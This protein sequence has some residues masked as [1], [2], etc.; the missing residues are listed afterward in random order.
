MGPAPLG[1]VKPL[2]RRSRP[3]RRGRAGEVPSALGRWAEEPK[4]RSLSELSL[5]GSCCSSGVGRQMNAALLTMARVLRSRAWPLPPRG[6]CRPRRPLAGKGSLFA[7][8]G[9]G[10]ASPGAARRNA[11]RKNKPH[12][13]SRGVYFAPMARPAASATELK[14]TE[15][16]LG[17][18]GRKGLFFGRFCCRGSPE[19][20]RQP[21]AGSQPVSK[22]ARALRVVLHHEAAPWRCSAPRLPGTLRPR[23]RPRT[24]RLRPARARRRTG[25]AAVQAEERLRT[26]ERP[27]GASTKTSPCGSPRPPA[28]SQVAM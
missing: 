28:G 14:V 13:A 9:V 17:L 8:L 10:L 4:L 19:M 25:G 11:R 15:Y 21:E 16:L 27:P 24:R 18:R 1:A 7:A 22:A 20:Q 26:A 12:R 6:P 2:A 5:R 3:K 23:P